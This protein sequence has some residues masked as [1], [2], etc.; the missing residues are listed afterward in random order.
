MSRHI[1]DELVHGET[2]EL[3]REKH[4][5]TVQVGKGW[6][7]SGWLD[8]EQ[9]IPNLHGTGCTFHTQDCGFFKSILAHSTYCLVCYD[10]ISPHQLAYWIV[11]FLHHLGFS[12]HAKRLGKVVRVTPDGIEIWQIHHRKKVKVEWIT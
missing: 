10:R 3:L 12:T 9:I 2:I 7:Q 6:G 5:A 11:R 1:I 4:I 8:L